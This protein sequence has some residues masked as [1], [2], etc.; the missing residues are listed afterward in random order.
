[1][2][3]YIHIHKHTNAHFDEI[4]P[5]THTHTHTL[6]TN[7]LFQ[8]HMHTHTHTIWTRGDVELHSQAMGAAVNYATIGRERESKKGLKGW[9]LAHLEISW[10][11]HV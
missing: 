2:Y 5:D 11:V 1:M 8:L 7:T 9:Q 10:K 6:Q 4:T 3:T